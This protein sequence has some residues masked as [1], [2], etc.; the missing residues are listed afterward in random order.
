MATFYISIVS[1]D[2]CKPAVYFAHRLFDKNGIIPEWQSNN[3]K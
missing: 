2:H 1:Y 3:D